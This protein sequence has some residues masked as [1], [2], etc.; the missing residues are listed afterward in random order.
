M[1]P[2]ETIWEFV[3]E[4]LVKKGFDVYEFPDG[5]KN[6]QVVL[7]QCNVQGQQLNK[8]YLNGVVDF[9]IHVLG[10][11]KKKVMQD[12]E[13]I[14]TLF[15]GTWDNGIEG[16][17]DGFTNGLSVETIEGHWSYASRVVLQFKL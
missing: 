9:E 1:N 8:D 7:V 11:D 16:I 10:K 2:V 15:T 12:T 14:S 6:H 4:E 3:G 5:K 13:M 17:G